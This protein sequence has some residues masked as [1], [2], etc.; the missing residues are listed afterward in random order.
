MSEGLFTI[1]KFMTDG[2]VQPMVY[3]AASCSCAS[4]IC[5]A[6]SVLPF[7]QLPP[8]FS[9]KTDRRMFPFSTFLTVAGLLATAHARIVSIAQIAPFQATADSL[10]SVT[11]VTENG[12]SP[13]WDYAAAIGV[14]PVKESS[15]AATDEDALGAVV[16]L[17]NFVEQGQSITGTGNFTIPVPVTTNNSIWAGNGDYILKAA[18]LSASGVAIWT[19]AQYLNQTFSVVVA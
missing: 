6:L 8:P 19:D 11:F 5:S 13:V 2:A 14:A 9:T 4:R 10:L 16:L 1:S 17:A 12:Q 18:L 7:S 15:P 3:N